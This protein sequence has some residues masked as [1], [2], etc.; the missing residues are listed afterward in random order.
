MRGFLIVSERDRLLHASADDELWAL[1]R[2]KVTAASVLRAS[3]SPS[4][5]SGV[6]S[7]HDEELDDEEE[8]Y[9]STNRL[10]LNDIGLLVLPMV[11]LYR[12]S[13]VM[14]HDEYEK[15]ESDA[16]RLVFRRLAG[17]FLLI[18]ICERFADGALSEL[19][20]FVSAN[21]PKVKKRSE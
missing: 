15:L 4:T 20:P 6:S 3:Q 13:S 14:N 1:W 17:G 9:E 7:D 19:W 2:S 18:S 11:A 16:G 21:K 12:S 10:S 5:S 8:E